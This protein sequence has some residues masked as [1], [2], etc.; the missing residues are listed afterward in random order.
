MVFIEARLRAMTA[1]YLPCESVLH[2]RRDVLIAQLRFTANYIFFHLRINVSTWNENTNS[3]TRK[4]VF[5]N[6]FLRPH[7][8]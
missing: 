3:E 5:L 1:I 7:F 2:R 8:E 6:T 4:L